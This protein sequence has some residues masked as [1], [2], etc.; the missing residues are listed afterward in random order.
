MAENGEKIEII[1]S[2]V[3]ETELTSEEKKNITSDISAQTVP[4]ENE[5]EQTDKPDSEK[6]I[7]KAEKKEEKRR[8]NREAMKKTF[9][10]SNFLLG[11][12]LCAIVAAVVLLLAFVNYFTAPVISASQAEKGNKARAELVPDASSFVLYEGEIPATGPN[13]SAV[14]IA[15]KDGTEIAYCLDISASGF[16]GEIKLVTAVGTDMKVLGIKVISHSETAGIG[17]AA[18]DEKAAL[19]PQYTNLPASSVDNVIAVSGATVTSTAVKNCIK[20][21]TAVVGALVKGAVSQ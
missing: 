18:L 4:S 17:A 16:G 20:E 8:K 7:S 5:A 21:A 11:L 2:E 3:L 19:L 9:A 6:E 12:R 14:Y 15:E 13:V 10:A 1:E